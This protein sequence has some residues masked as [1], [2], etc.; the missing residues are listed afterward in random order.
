MPKTP[1]TAAATRKSQN[2]SN[3]FFFFSSNSKPQPGAKLPQQQPSQAKSSH[4]LCCQQC[5]YVACNLTDLRRHLIVHSNEQ[6]YHCCACDF[7]SKWK[8]DVKKHQ[9]SLNHAGPILV[10][11]KAMQKVIESLG[12]DRTS[13][14]TLYGPNIQVIDNKQC[15]SN[16]KLIDED[17]LEY[18]NKNVSAGKQDG[19]K[20]QFK[21]NVINKTANVKETSGQYFINQAQNGSHKRKHDCEDELCDDEEYVDEEEEED[22]YEQLNEE[23]EEGEEDVDVDVDE[24][25]E[26]L[27]ESHPN[28]DQNE[29]YEETYNEE[30]FE[31]DYNEE[32]EE[33]QAPQEEE[34]H[35]EAEGE[36]EEEENQHGDANPTANYE[37]NEN[38]SDNDQEL[39]DQEELDIDQDDY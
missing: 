4:S 29:L 21:R 5:P 11:K 31:E 30:N 26:E 8:S 1:K 3:V 33:N 7:K 16:E 32:Y 37:L 10:G 20:M 35:E 13:M 15:K 24:E 39:N 12:L 23:D 14:V 6:P 38:Y 34:A 2:I 17:N 9:R 18:K 36:E 25:Y 22:V 28:L 27:N 19:L